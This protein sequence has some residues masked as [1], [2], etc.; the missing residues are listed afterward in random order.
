MN[1]T[2]PMPF[3]E[4]LSAA[5]IKSLLPTSGSHADMQRLGS[6]IKRRAFWSATVE[7][8]RVLQQMQDSTR[9]LLSGQVDQATERLQIKQLLAEMGYQPDPEKIGGLQDISSTARLNLVLETQADI[10]RGA[11]WYQQGMQEDVLD[12]FPAQELVREVNTLAPRGTHGT[13]SWPDRWQQAGGVFYGGRM[14]ALKTDPIWQKLGDPKLFPDALGNPFPPFAFNSGMGVRD[15]D[16]TEAEDL[17]IL[18]ANTRLMPQPLDLNA[19]LQASPDVRDQGLRAL[20]EGTGAGHF[21]G[22]VFVFNAAAA[23]LQGN[24]GGS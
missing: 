10:A 14:I 15:V 7:S 5:E 17:G 9:D 21:D 6:E 18:D 19:D 12:E 1:L 8:G 20:M 23:P 22:D 16:R 3:Q 4:A 13:V 24:G 11:G 2:A